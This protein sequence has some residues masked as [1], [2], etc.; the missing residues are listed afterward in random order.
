MTHVVEVG[1][2]WRAI[3]LPLIYTDGGLAVQKTEAEVIAKYEAAGGY[4]GSA[5]YLA[6][7]SGTTKEKAILNARDYGYLISKQQ[8]LIFDKRFPTYVGNEGTTPNTAGDST[9]N[10]T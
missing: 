7:L 6:V 4:S 3:L 5:K 1:S 9:S 8:S 2:E 10:W